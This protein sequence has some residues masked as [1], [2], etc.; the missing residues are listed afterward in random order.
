MKFKS[1]E[2][3]QWHKRFAIL[4]KKIGAQWVWLESYEERLID[5]YWIGDD[6]AAF[7]FERRFEAGQG[8][9]GTVK[10]YRF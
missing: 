1:K 3:K 6:G 10:K 2:L 7:V 9:V 5:S 8:E 4:P